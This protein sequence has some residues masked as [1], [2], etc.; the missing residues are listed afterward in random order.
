MLTFKTHD[1]DHETKTDCM[2]GKQK[3]TMKK[4]SQ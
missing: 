3:K 2:K 1:R 4:N